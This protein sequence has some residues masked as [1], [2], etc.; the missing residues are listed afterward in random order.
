MGADAGAIPQGVD[1][2]HWSRREI[3]TL[4][5]KY[6]SDASLL[7]ND[8][9]SRKDLARIF[10][11]VLERVV[12]RC[13]RDGTDVIPREELD[14]IAVL[15]DELKDDLAQFDGYLVRR[16]A[17]E[18]VLAKPEEPKFDYSIGVAGFFRGE[19]T[20][21]FPLKDF[22][23]APDRSE[24]RFLYRAKPYAYWHPTDYLDL[25]LEGQGYGF[26]G[27]GPDYG[28]VYLYQGFVEGKLPQGEWLALKAGRQEFSYGSTFILGPDS[29]YDGLSFDALR[30]RVKPSAVLTIDL[31][32][33][34]YAR[35]SSDGVHGDLAGIYASYGLSDGAA[36][37]AYIFRDSGALERHDGEQLYIWGGRGTA[38]FGPLSLEIEP[39]YE[40]GR[41]F[42]P[43]TGGN[44]R[45]EA[46]GGHLDATVDTP[47]AGRNGKLFLSVAYGSGSSTAA[48][49]SSL[50]KEFRN[51]NND[52]S[53]MGDMSVLSDL[54]G[55]TVGDYHA[56][57]LQLY[58][59][60]WGV[61]IS[62]K[63]NISA[64]GHYV[65]ANYVPDGFSRQAGLEADFSLI[66]SVS[67]DISVILS[68]D[69]FFTGRFFRDATGSRDDI[70]YGYLMVQ[71]NL[72]KTKLRT[73]AK[74]S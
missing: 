14:R 9:I 8:P 51:A 68:Y 66:Y 57:G 49:G 5:Q 40:S 45:I 15:Y 70:D 41:R 53:L 64:T 43:A 7:I 62:R 67:D 63:M 17:I 31:L 2:A 30:L 23:Y 50:R 24:G 52:N 20:G 37:D 13:E 34:Y 35:S 18:G 60:G 29:F 11:T 73:P 27:S 21:N 72:A 1:S 61:D 4:A 48:N 28:R 32:G 26:N 69:H 25:H 3:S 6:G 22:S 10:L 65:V 19:G 74:P 42:N 59:L 12:S 38:T 55:L 39:V 46:Y 54:S 33:G 16:E 56:S 44:E 71:F 36:V 58:T 47:V